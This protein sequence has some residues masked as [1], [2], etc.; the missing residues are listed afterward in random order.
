MPSGKP[1]P[2]SYAMRAG[3]S[4]YRSP[5]RASSGASTSR[6]GRHRSPLS[7]S[8]SDADPI[9][10]AFSGRASSSHSRRSSSVRPA[11][12]RELAMVPYRRGRSASAASSSL[13]PSDAASGALLARYQ[14]RLGAGSAVSS[15]LRPSDSV[16]STSLCP[17]T[18]DCP[19]DCACRRWV[20]LPQLPKVLRAAASPARADGHGGGIRHAGGGR[21]TVPVSA[22]G[23]YAERVPL[24][25]VPLYRIR[26]VR[27][28][29][30]GM[31]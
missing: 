30:D 31:S 26:M 23:S 16:S 15:P 8:S 11:S 10:R 22:A 7:Q 17:E 28:K 2:T 4:R 29:G 20:L 12:E 25:H 18:R 27:G 1:P 19:A 13:H 9:L 6:A 5:S 14:A 24:R 21:R 3:S